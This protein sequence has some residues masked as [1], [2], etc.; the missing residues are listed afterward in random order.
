MWLL[1][2]DEASGVA[3]PLHMVDRSQAGE[4]TQL[5]KLA[6]LVDFHYAAICYLFYE[7]E[8]ASF[9]VPEAWALII[10]ADV[11]NAYGSA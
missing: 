7:A 11:I 1:Q 5:G 9:E 10:G 6:C 8:E 2:A 4:G 3:Q